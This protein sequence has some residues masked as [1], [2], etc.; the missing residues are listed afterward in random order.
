MEQ[1]LHAAGG[2]LKFDRAM[3]VNKQLCIRSGGT[4]ADHNIEVV[5]CKEGRVVGADGQVRIFDVQHIKGLEFEAVFFVGVDQ[6]AER[7]PDL[8]DKF[9][10][11]GT[12]RASTYLGISCSGRLPPRLEPLRPLF[13]TDDWAGQ[14]SP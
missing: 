10:Y 1:L 2:D 13:S 9:L 7:V 5:G 14:P 12:T 6:L 4:L 3:P 8:F 11:V